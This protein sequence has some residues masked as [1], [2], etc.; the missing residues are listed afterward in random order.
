MTLG[1]VIFRRTDLAGGRHPGEAALQA[2]ADL[3]ATELGWTASRREREL[4]EVRTRCAGSGWPADAS[5]GV[6]T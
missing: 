2:C 6:A 3:M 1:D 4:A 5:A